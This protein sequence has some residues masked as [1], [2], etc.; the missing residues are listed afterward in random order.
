MSVFLHTKTLRIQIYVT[1]SSN[2]FLLDTVNETVF[3]LS[4]MSKRQQCNV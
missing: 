1:P 2:K 3:L 4:D